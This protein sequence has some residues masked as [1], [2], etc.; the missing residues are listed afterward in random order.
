MPK[1]HTLKATERAKARE[2]SHQ[3][4]LESVFNNAWEHMLEQDGHRY[5]TPGQK[6]GMKKD[7]ASFLRGEWKEPS[8][9]AH[10]TMYFYRLCL[11]Q[12]PDYVLNDKSQYMTTCQEEKSG[13]DK[14][15]HTIAKLMLFEFDKNKSMFKHGGFRKQVQ[16]EKLLDT[17]YTDEEDSDTDEE[18]SDNE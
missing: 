1:A 14:G 16:R 3:K 17:T 15:A 2:E 7:I 9:Q 12:C 5:V 11:E 13:D 18:D 6:N 8:L 10:A 4:K